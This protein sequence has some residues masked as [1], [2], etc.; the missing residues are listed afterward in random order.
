MQSVNFQMLLFC[1]QKKWN[2]E[3]VEEFLRVIGKY[4]RHGKPPPKSNSNSDKADSSHN[5]GLNEVIRAIFRYSITEC[6]PKIGDGV[7]DL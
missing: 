1:F 4:Y 5:C 3:S 7:Q 2:S 6:K